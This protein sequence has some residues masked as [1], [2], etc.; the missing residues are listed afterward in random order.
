MPKNLIKHKKPDQVKIKN[1]DITGENTN[2]LPG[3]QIEFQ[4]NKKNSYW[5]EGTLIYKNY[6]ILINGQTKAESFPH[7]KI[8]PHT[9]DLEESASS[10][11]SN[12]E[13]VNADSESNKDV[14]K[15]LQFFKSVFR[16]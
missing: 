14:N 7:T 13:E 10:D 5:P 9:L 15:K 12:I 1:S 2:I 16:T 6:N 8:R 11:K 4:E 3:T